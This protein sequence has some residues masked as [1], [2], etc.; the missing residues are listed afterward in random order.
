M[1]SIN[2][3]VFDAYGT[4]FDVHS[5]ANR[6]AS[7]IGPQW[8][9]MSQ[10]WRT[11]H[12]EY[13]WLHAVTGRHTTFWTLAQRS[14]DFAAASCGGLSDDLKRKL[15]SAYRT[16][17]AYGEVKGVLTDL[18]AGGAKLAILTN[19]DPDM[20]AEAIK[21]ADLEGLF[22][23]VLTVHE[24]GVFKPDPRVYKL[25]TDRFEVAPAAISFQS[26]NRWDAAAAQVFGF[27][28]VWINRAGGPNEY[29]DMPPD[30][31]IGD[32]TTLAQLNF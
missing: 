28:T 15:L 11:K 25:A 6:Y 21:A 13:T 7:E 20:I 3:Y 32:L 10:I 24:A 8:E 17:G 2:H 23:A 5:A 22:D 4:L 16:L 18:K 26:S 12:I 31:T 9:R 27:R 1:A 30:H 14:L 19:G 29:P